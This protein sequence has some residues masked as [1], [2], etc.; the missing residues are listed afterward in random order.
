MIGEGNRFVFFLGFARRQ[1]YYTAE[2]LIKLDSRPLSFRAEILRERVCAGLAHA[3]IED[4]NF[5]RATK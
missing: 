3:R 5:L 1:A 2:T 4:I